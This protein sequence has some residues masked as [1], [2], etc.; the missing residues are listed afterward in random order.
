[1]LQGCDSKTKKI[2][3]CLLIFKFFVLN[4]LTFWLETRHVSKC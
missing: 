1:M 2:H 3:I 4:E